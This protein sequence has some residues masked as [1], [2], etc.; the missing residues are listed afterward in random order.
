MMRRLTVE[1]HHWIY[2]L[3]FGVFY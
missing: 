3:V 2:P 1:T